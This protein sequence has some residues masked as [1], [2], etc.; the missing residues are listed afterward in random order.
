[1]VVAA[2]WHRLAQAALLLPKLPISSNNGSCLLAC[3]AAMAPS[4]VAT[5]ATVVVDSHRNSNRS[6]HRPCSKCRPPL[7][8]ESHSNRSSNF[9][10]QPPNRLLLLVAE[11]PQQV[12]IVVTTI[13]VIYRLDIINQFNFKLK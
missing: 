6:P 13:A 12:I 2:A 11:E 10:E 1:M 4:V 7:E 8:L 3:P 5:P 9:T